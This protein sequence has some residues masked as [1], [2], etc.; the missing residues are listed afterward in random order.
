MKKLFG[1]T[2]SQ[3]GF[4]I[5]EIVI[6]IT[7]ILLV[8]V[9]LAR[10]IASSLEASNEQQYLTHCVFLAQLKL[11]EVRTRANC[12]TNKVGDPAT[13]CPITQTSSDFNTAL[14]NQSP[15]C[16]FPFPF[17]NYEC[18]VEYVSSTREAGIA[19]RLKTIQVRVWYDKNNDDTFDPAEG[20]PDIFLETQ[21]AI[22]PPNW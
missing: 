18:T 9:P 21:L 6:V 2:P 13:K 16:D 4:T 14:L 7:L 20:E 11:E 19:D 15:P 22:R 12:Y 8:I 10:V 5:V 1:R 3:K 17:T